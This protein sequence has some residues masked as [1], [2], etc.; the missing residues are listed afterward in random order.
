M[1]VDAPVTENKKDNKPAKQPKAVYKQ[2][3]QVQQ[4]QTNC[5]EQDESIQ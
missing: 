3:Q 2:K 1:K 5:K 4:A